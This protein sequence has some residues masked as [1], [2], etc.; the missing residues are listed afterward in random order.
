VG[1]VAQPMIQPF[2]AYN[3]N[4]QPNNMVKS[5]YNANFDRPNYP[6]KPHFE[7]ISIESIKKAISFR[8]KSTNLVLSKQPIDAKH[9]IEKRYHYN[10]DIDE[11]GL[12]NFTLPCTPHA[13]VFSL[14]ISVPIK[15]AEEH[16]IKVEEERNRLEE[17]EK[18]KAKELMSKQ[19]E[20]AKLVSG[21]DAKSAL[22]PIPRTHLPEEELAKTLDQF[23]AGEK[24]LMEYCVK[25]MKS[26]GKISLQQMMELSELSFCKQE[27]SERNYVVGVLLESKIL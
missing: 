2:P 23:N 25:N 13:D 5:H 11:V 10:I 21:Y 16:K 8:V 20:L 3:P 7:P 12:Q 9:H 14:Y 4:I 19:V 22:Y 24:Q 27:P 18:I 6:H 1:G 15:E 26:K 17:Q